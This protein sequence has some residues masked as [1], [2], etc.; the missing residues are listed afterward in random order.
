MR[1]PYPN[2]RGVFLWR[3]CGRLQ[4]S[5]SKRNSNLKVKMTNF[6]A[7]SLG[8]GITV[9][10]LIAAATEGGESGNILQGGAVAIM[11]AIIFF[12][13]KTVIPDMQKQS[14]QMAD[15]FS[16]TLIK[17]M[18]DSQV[19][20]KE[21]RDEFREMLK[22]DRDI[23]LRELGIAQKNII[24]QVAFEHSANVSGEFKRP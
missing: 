3:D 20:Q 14:L 6:I 4:S 23:L 17:I 10:G 13:F 22:A 12:L 19:N 24:R 9:S 18:Q 11:G 21:A 5:D 15:K 8:G 2:W 16:T 7:W 1:A